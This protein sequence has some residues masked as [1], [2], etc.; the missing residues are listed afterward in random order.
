[1]G[2]K[3]SWGSCPPSKMAVPEHGE[4]LICFCQAIDE[5]SGMHELNTLA[6]MP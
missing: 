3:I 5:H 6:A 4:S 1:M 2:S